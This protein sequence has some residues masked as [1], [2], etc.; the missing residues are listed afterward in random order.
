[1]YYFARPFATAVRT[2]ALAIALLILPACA[3]VPDAHPSITIVE[4]ST[5]AEPRPALPDTL[6]AGLTTMAK[7]S[8]RP[9]DA[10]VLIITS[11]TGSTVIS[12]DLTPL[13]T[14]GQVQ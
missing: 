11:A 13:R 10:T 7:N 1:M 8:K 3:T 4:T 6:A 5:S 2:T 12:K 14:N 9:G